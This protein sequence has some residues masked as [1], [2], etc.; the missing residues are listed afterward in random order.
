MQCGYANI[1][2]WGFET[3]RGTAF[4]ACIKAEKDED[5]DNTEPNTFLALISAGTKNVYHNR[6]RQRY[7]SDQ[8]YPYTI[9]EV[10]YFFT[11]KNLQKLIGS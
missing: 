2:T 4:G 10:V 7:L 8:G 3:A 6:N 1:I 9:Q 11:T 5:S